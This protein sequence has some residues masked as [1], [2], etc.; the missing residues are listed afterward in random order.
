MAIT[1]A[2]GLPIAIR[3]SGAS[4][5]EVKLIEDTIKAWH[6]KQKLKRIIGDRAYD[7]DP[8]DERLK[9]KKIELIAPHRS[10]RRKKITQDGRKLRRYCKR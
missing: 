2:A 7:S 5:P 3:A 8:L 10:N 4:T 9:N 1:D 6:I